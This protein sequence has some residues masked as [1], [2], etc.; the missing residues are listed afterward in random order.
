MAVLIALVGLT[1]VLA[2][3]AVGWYL[4]SLN[5]RCP[6]CGAAVSCAVCGESPARP[7]RSP[8]TGPHRRKADNHA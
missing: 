4:R 5:G 2:G 3:L 1:G 7:Y 6:Q 8:S